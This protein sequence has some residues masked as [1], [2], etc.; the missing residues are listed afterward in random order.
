M[1]MC[2]RPMCI[3]VFFYESQLY[4]AQGQMCIPKQ[5]CKSICYLKGILF[6]VRKCTQNLSQS[7]PKEEGKL[8]KEDRTE[9]RARFE[10]FVL[11]RDAWPSQ[12]ILPVEASTL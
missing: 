8:Q 12:L 2:A 6:S 9:N 3:K 11:N 4:R 7:N 1:C 5:E 10:A